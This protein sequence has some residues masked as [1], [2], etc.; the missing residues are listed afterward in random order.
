[1][2]KETDRLKLPLPLGNE[3]VTRESINGIFEKIDAGVATREAILISAGSD[4]NSYI[5]EGEYYCP[6][7]ATVETLANSPTGVAFHLTIER[8]AGVVQTLTTFEPGDLQVFQRNYYFGWGL[9]KKVP[10]MDEIEEVKLLGVEQKA[11]VVAVL[12][13][14]G[15]SAST[16]ES[17]AQL[18]TKMS[19]IIRATGNTTTADVIAGRTFS[20]LN[21]NGLTGTIP[22]RGPGGIVTPGASDQTKAEGRYTT[23]ITIKGEPNLIAG[24]LPKDKTF[25][26]IAGLLE[27]MTTSEKQSIANQITAK[28]VRATTSDSNVVLA[29]KIGMI[30][31]SKYAR[32]SLYASEGQVYVSGVAFRPKLVKLYGQY[33]SNESYFTACFLFDEPIHSV[34]G[35]IPPDT[36]INGS[37]RSGFGE[38]LTV[39]RI[40]NDGF[41][42]TNYNWRYNQIYW[43]AWGH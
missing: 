15:L 34:Y 4:L 11:N 5:T 7:N 18:I 21:A 37:G 16:I 13:S 28:G 23:A 42:V 8:H 35:I 25:F 38:T 26:G 40:S 43:E 24:N 2:P 31:T 27:R 6:E 30:E 19:G 33:S 22:D 20:N 36:S 12:N 29:Q 1:M 32:G 17:W 3:N 10:T 39:N 41:G 14:I 9:W